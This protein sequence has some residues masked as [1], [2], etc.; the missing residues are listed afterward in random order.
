MTEPQ[1]TTLPCTHL[2]QLCAANLKEEK[3]W[4]EFIRRYNAVLVRS[5]NL[6]IHQRAGAEWPRHLSQADILQD[7]YLHI[8]KDDCQVLRRF[9]GETE[10]EAPI[11]LAQIATNIALDCL[12]RQ[13]SQKRH[14]EMVRLEEILWENEEA[15]QLIEHSGTRGGPP[16]PYTEEIAE[17]ELIVLLR[18][19]C[20]GRHSRRDI[21]IS[22]LHFREG[23][24]AREI[25]ESG[26]CDLQPASISH[27][28]A[29]IKDELKK[30][31]F[32]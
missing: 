9:R 16:S 1:L 5:V 15:N 13:Q 22:P 27:V 14:P 12:R 23:L 25:A 31:F 17:Q 26:I 7:I 24:S 19:I 10:K 18:R 29:Q 21:L 4:A 3:Y 8:L 20:T 30:I 32:D 11:Y 6:I 28:L 2:F